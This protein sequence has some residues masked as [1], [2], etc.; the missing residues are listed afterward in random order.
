MVP[1]GDYGI[2]F[3]WGVFLFGTQTEE[4]KD[5][6]RKYAQ[7][8]NLWDHPDHVI[9]YCLVGRSSGRQNLVEDVC[10]HARQVLLCNSACR[11]IYWTSRYD[12][13]KVALQVD[14]PAKRV[15]ACDVSVRLDEHGI[16]Y[17]TEAGTGCADDLLQYHGPD[18]S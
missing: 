4:E 7:I 14:C 18:P 1:S 15:I 16:G 10:T 5:S 11:H 2:I 13:Q 12:Q 6:Y 17:G 9:D 8:R 3:I